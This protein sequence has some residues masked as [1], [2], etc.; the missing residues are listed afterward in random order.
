[1]SETLERRGMAHHSAIAL[2]AAAALAFPA[3]AEAATRF[4]EPGG[5]GPASSCP[6]A[7]PCDLDAAIGDPSVDDGDEVILL[8]GEYAP[9]GFVS[10]T[11][12]IN[13]HGR[14]SDP[15][16]LIRLS[17]QSSVILNHSGATISDLAIEG[18]PY[19]P[20]APPG[21]AFSARAGVAERLHV[22]GHGVFSACD[23]DGGPS[24]PVLI[25]DS[26][27]WST[28]RAASGLGMYA[29]GFG[30]GAVE[31][32]TIVNVTAA[33]V[34]KGLSIWALG[35]GTG[36]LRATNVIARS[37]PEEARF[38][39]SADVVAETE[40]PG[41]VA[42]PAGERA[43]IELSGSNYASIGTF[44]PNT[45]VTAAGTGTNQTATPILASPAAGDFRQMV[46][47]PTI[48][49]GLELQS[50]GPFDFEGQARVQG[51]APDIGADEG[52]LVTA[53]EL[54]AAARQLLRRLRVDVGCRLP[55]CGIEAY[56]VIK[57]KRRDGQAKRPSFRAA[58]RLRLKSRRLA[59]ADGEERRVRL[60]LPPKQRRAAKRA[61]A[62]GA[63]LKAKI[64]VDTGDAG[65][66]EKATVKIA[67]PR[68]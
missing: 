31:E 55:V 15:R 43:T 21:P 54:S 52:S 30:V 3:V 20:G 18:A 8:P 44:G 61:L 53:I 36:T 41:V 40:P 37:D 59:L 27:C 9:P 1:M 23:A 17:G 63:K 19:D 48:D 65:A 67:R 13:V 57:V 39:G 2:V 33:G 64:T 51:P 5:D 16:P 34:K 29:P 22:T 47:S 35:G 4:A 14:R 50:L 12:P 11:R 10:I 62:A 32:A 46:G 42:T 45:S 26:V 25:R 60:K 58:K 7:N 49:A 66:R 56:G 24:R 6:E 28:S 38:P 68:S